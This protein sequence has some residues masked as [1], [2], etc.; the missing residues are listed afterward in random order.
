M[1]YDISFNFK[2]NDNELNDKVIEALQKIADNNYDVL[3][4]FSF[5]NN[6]DAK[7]ALS[8]FVDSYPGPN[9]LR[10]STIRKLK[11]KV[12]IDLLAG[13][14][15]DEFVSLLMDVIAALGGTPL[16]SKAVGEQGDIYTY[17]YTKKGMSVSLDEP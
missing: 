6:A 11:T 1:E 4:A 17:K 2:F 8:K 3:S 16:T 5:V 12:C 14:A 9:I 7:L 10:H 15:E 13:H